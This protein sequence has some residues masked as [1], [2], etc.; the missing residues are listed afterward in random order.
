MTLTDAEYAYLRSELGEADRTDLD[1]RY[2]RLGS[3][4]AVAAEV[5]RERK[6]A[7]VSDP[8]AVTVQ[9]VAT[10]NNAENVRALERQI[11]ALE[12]TT[13]NENAYVFPA[14]LLRRRSR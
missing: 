5:L 4:Q 9:G 6:A 10:V 1:A 14:P 2:Q 7:L 11:A 12:D 13:P 3:V 8:L